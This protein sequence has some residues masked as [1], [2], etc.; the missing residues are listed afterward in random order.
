MPVNLKKRSKKRMKKTISHVKFQKLIVPRPD[1]LHGYL[2]HEEINRYLEYLKN[3]YSFVQLHVL[4]LTHERRQLKAI[5]IDWNSEQ[6][7]QAVERERTRRML[8]DKSAVT[9]PPQ[10]VKTNVQGRNTIFIEAGTHAREWISVAVALNCIYQLT[11]KHLR[12]YE[13]LRKLRFIIVP[14]TNPD[15]YEYTFVKNRRWRKNR[16][17]IRH[18]R[19]IGTDCNR[20]YDFHW[21]DGPSKSGRNTFKGLKPFSEPE[22]RAMRNILRKHK[23]NLLFFLSL[24]SYAESIMYPWGYSKDLPET[25]QKLEK[26]ALA[27]RNAIKAY[28][29]RSYR[30]GSIAKLTKRRISGSIVDYV[31]GVIN[32]PLALVMELP[33]QALGFQPP[34]ESISPIGHESWFGI[35]EMCKMAYD[36]EAPFLKLEGT[37]LAKALTNARQPLHDADAASNKQPLY[38]ALMP[39]IKAEQ[40]LKNTQVPVKG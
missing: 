27:G 25:W 20:N 34:A 29:G 14:V 12:N 18:S 36:I 39:A 17:P 6:N 28:N 16:R 37:L 31:F 13:L 1:V 11:E 15:G 38:R 23:E 8:H 24:H 7:L 32:T 35:R 33:S 4:G 19:H 2:R 22:T 9:P 30:V 40:V 26:L 5:E 3:R 10:N 21:E